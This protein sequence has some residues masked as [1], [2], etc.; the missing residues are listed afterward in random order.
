LAYA[1]KICLE[2]ILD[3]FWFDKIYNFTQLYLFSSQ[4][5]FTALRVN[6]DR[7]IIIV[8]RYTLNILLAEQVS[9]I[10]DDHL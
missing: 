3:I 2:A 7:S 5:D 8:K 10:T 9:V 6:W 1:T 4:E